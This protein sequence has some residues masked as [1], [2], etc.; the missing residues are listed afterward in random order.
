MM[1]QPVMSRVSDT[2]PVDRAVIVGINAYPVRTS[3]PLKDFTPLDGCVNDARAIAD[4]VVRKRGFNR[5]Q[6]R[7]LTDAAAVSYTHLTLPPT[8][9]V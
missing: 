6:V 4:F 7:L 2:G 8:D 5:S 9:L 1:R 3:G